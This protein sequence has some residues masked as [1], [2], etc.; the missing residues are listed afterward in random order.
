MKSSPGMQEP[1]NGPNE[2]HVTHLKTNLSY[3][4][5]RWTYTAE[6][7]IDQYSGYI[8]FLEGENNKCT[9]NVRVVMV[10]KDNALTVHP[11]GAKSPGI[12]S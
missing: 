11:H 3:Q 4:R 2:D 5:K 8:Y 6:L 12:T 9:I 1:I 10:V 7:D